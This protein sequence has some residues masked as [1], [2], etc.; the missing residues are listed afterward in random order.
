MDSIWVLSVKTSLP[1]VCEKVEDMKTEFFAFGSFED[2]KQALKNKLK[3]FAFSENSMFDGN[4]NMIYLKHYLDVANDRFGQDG[5]TSELYM[6][7]KKVQV[8]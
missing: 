6:D 5:S 2:A 7:L 4:G 1:Y 8:K 3:E